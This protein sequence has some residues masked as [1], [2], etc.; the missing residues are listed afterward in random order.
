MLLS[1]RGTLVASWE[2]KRVPDVSRSSSCPAMAVACSWWHRR[3][4]VVQSRSSYPSSLESGAAAGLERTHGLRLALNDTRTASTH[5][6]PYAARDVLRCAMLVDERRQ[7]RSSL[8]SSYVA[9]VE[10]C[11][12]A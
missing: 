12:R 4:R 10:S 11:G 6:T 9:S 7:K 8:S 5:S 2:L 3:S 1:G